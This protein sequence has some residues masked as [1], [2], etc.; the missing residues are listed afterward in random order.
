MDSI[1]G[2]LIGLWPLAFGSRNQAPYIVNSIDHS[3]VLNRQ[4]TY[5]P[6]QAYASLQLIDEVSATCY[7]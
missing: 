4:P 7:V 2:W 5:T 6:T 1:V 3:V